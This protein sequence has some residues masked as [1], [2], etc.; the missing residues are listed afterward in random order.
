[1]AKGNIVV[2]WGD[3]QRTIH[4]TGIQAKLEFWLVALWLRWQLWRGIKGDDGT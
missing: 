1:M 2:S 4:T 3:E